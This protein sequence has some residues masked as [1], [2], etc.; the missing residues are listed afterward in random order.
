MQNTWQFNNVKSSYCSGLDVLFMAN[1]RSLRNKID[2]LALCLLAK[3]VDI[4]VITE[5]WIYEDED[6]SHYKVNGYRVLHFPRGRLGGGISIYLKQDKFRM[7]EVITPVSREPCVSQIAVLWCSCANMILVAVYFTPAEVHCRSTFLEDWLSSCFEQVI[8]R[9]GTARFIIAGDFNRLNLSDFSAI[10][11]LNCMVVDATR[12]SVTLDQIL[13]HSSLANTFHTAEI[14]PPL[15]RSDYRSVIMIRRPSQEKAKTSSLKTK[16]CTKT[17]VNDLTA[18]M[19]VQ[20]LGNI[21]WENYN[22]L[23]DL[24]DKVDFL[25]S[26]LDR[27]IDVVPLKTFTKNCADKPWFTNKLKLLIRKR[28]VFYKNRHFPGY[29]MLHNKIKAEIREAKFKW[30]QRMEAKKGKNAIWEALKLWKPTGSSCGVNQSLNGKNE[31]AINDYQQMVKGS[32][33]STQTYFYDPNDWRDIQNDDWDI[34]FGVKEVLE[35][36]NKLS[37]G[38]N[39]GPSKYP[40]LF[41]KKAAPILAN[42]LTHIFNLSVTSRVFPKKW[43]FSHLIPIPKKGIMTSQNFRPIMINDCFGKI[44]EKLV[45]RNLFNNHNLGK[46]YSTAQHGF[47]KQASVNTLI[48]TL[49]DYLVTTLEDC[50]VANASVATFDIVKAFDRVDHKLMLKFLLQTE[51]PR[52]FA[53]WFFSF[54]TDR[55]CAV[56]LNDVVGEQ[57]I[58]PSGVPQGGVMSPIMFAIFISQLNLTKSVPLIYAD[59]ISIIIKHQKNGIYSKEIVE[60]FWEVKSQLEKLKLTINDKKTQLMTCVTAKKP[61]VDLYLEMFKRHNIPQP[62]ATINIL[63]VLMNGRLNWSDHIDYICN[64]AKKRLYVLRKLKQIS[65]KSNL[66]SVYE[67]YIRSILEYCGVA[68]IGTSKNNLAKLSSVQSKAHKAICGWGCNCDLLV[69]LNVRR[70]QQAIDLFITASNH[71]N[72]PLHLLTPKRLQHTKRFRA[73]PA[74]RTGQFQFDF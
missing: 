69:D 62:A 26:A 56:K 18:E 3:E 51:L 71:P 55:Y 59:D 40:A 52:G 21:E 53:I 41:I 24:D 12:G 17:V 74:F 31:D 27:A 4:A 58:I 30:F 70:Q 9:H 60:S 15:G 23:H 65:N 29:Q 47:K 50:T 36:I 37:D 49:H 45:L 25:H 19:F 73:I 64:K 67:A 34:Q 44:L 61:D 22:K 54:L 66:K 11:D 43:K 1:A 33:L 68:F 10:Y 6:V 13:V 57:F 48:I 28:W 14:G 72:H 63:G 32:F 39:T 7:E 16:S 35:E 38:K 5:S 46:Y 20:E 2:E 42:V 8:S